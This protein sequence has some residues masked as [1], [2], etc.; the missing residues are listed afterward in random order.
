MLAF[1]YLKPVRRFGFRTVAGVILLF[2]LFLCGIFIVSWSDIKTRPGW[3]GNHLENLTTLSI[4]LEERPVEKAKSYKLTAQIIRATEDEALIPVTGKIIIYLPKDSQVLSLTKGDELIIKNHLKPIEN[5]ENEKGFDYRRYMAL[6]GIYHQAYLKKDSWK[7][8]GRNHQNFLGRSVQASLSYFHGVFQDKLKGTEEIALV[9]AL[10]TGDRTELDRD[11]VQA[12][13]NTGV[14]HIMAISGLHLGLIYLF[15]VR[16]TQIIPFL[17]RSNIFKITVVLAGIWFF[18]FMTGCSP[19]VMRAAV[20][21]SFLSLGILKKIKTTT[22]NF[23]AAA[24]FILLWFNPLLLFNVGFQL[25]FLAVLGILVVQRPVYNWFSFQNKLADYLWQLMSVSIAAQLFT[26]PLCLYY[27]HQFPVLF[28]VANLVAIPL[29][30]TGL[31]L[32]VILLMTSWVPLLNNLVSFLVETSFNWLN[33]FVRH[34]DSFSFSVWKGIEINEAETILL[35]LVIIFL[36]SWLMKKSKLALSFALTCM[37]GMAVISGYQHWHGSQQSRNG[38]AQS[39]Q[40]SNQ[41]V[42]KN[43]VAA[44]LQPVFYNSAEIFDKA[45]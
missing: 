9:K 5:F 28:L 12:Y 21:F 35:S 18:A 39:G 15:L 20:M 6:Q 3:Y 19:S 45:R 11:L 10:L 43:D 30:S 32:G 38:L 13:S 22:Y 8:T 33:R 31:W 36:L 23:W 40:S 16:L 17:R 44:D 42:E 1:E 7:F 25:S 34:L 37:I 29:A 41:L 26:M 4:V 2:M 14:V 24:A 27:F